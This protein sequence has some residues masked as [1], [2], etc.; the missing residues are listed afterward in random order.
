MR[1]FYKEPS[2]YH[3]LTDEEYEREFE[4]KRLYFNEPIYDTTPVKKSSIYL[5]SSRLSIAGLKRH[6]RGWLCTLN[7]SHT[8]TSTSIV[9]AN[10]NIRKIQMLLQVDISQV[11]VSH[12]ELTQ[13]GRIQFKELTRHYIFQKFRY[14]CADCGATNKET[15]LHIDHIKPLARGGTNHISNLQVLCERCN[16][17]KHTDEW[18]GGQ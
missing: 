6:Y 14:R 9:L 13:N 1:S 5:V 11:K 17:V 16:L 3:A 18:V 8:S 15:T 12:D 2:K 7:R 10:L 4:H